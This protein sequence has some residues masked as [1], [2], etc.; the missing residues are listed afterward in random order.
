MSGFVYRVAYP[1]EDDQL[2]TAQV[3]RQAL[4]LFVD[5][6]LQ[7]GIR[8]TGD[9]AATIDGSRVVCEAPA[10]PLSGRRV[11]AADRHGLRIAELAA[12]GLSDSRIADVIGDGLTTAAVTY[13]RST[14]HIPSGTSQRRVSGEPA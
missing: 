4:V 7:R 3:I 12:A 10:Q 9:P 5:E 11:T 1:I 13:V 6:A 8:L 14:R 2:T